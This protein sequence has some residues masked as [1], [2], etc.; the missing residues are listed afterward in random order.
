[1]AERWQQTPPSPRRRAV[2][3]A[4]TAQA[5]LGNAQP[6]Q[7]EAAII[8]AR[9]M[10]LRSAEQIK[11]VTSLIFHLDRMQKTIKDQ[12]R[13]LNDINSKRSMEEARHG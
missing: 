9:R 10:K 7:L 6:L 1:M 3:S 8:A 13:Q 5:H 12:R 2:D 4:T 11:I